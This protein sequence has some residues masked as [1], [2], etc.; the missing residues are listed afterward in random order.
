MLIP[1]L[2]RCCIALVT[3]VALTSEAKAQ[4]PACPVVAMHVSTPADEAFARGDYPEAE[5]LYTHALAESS[6]DELQDAALVRT[7]LRE[8]KVAEAARE[9]AHLLDTHPAS[10]ALLTALAEVQFRQGVPWVAANTLDRVTAIDPCFARAHL[11]RSRLDRAD[12]MYR[13]ERSEI[14]TAYEIDSS[15]GEITRSWRQTVSTANDAVGLD[16]ALTSSKLDAAV[17][18]HAEASLKSLLSGLHEDS[19]TCRVLPADQ[20]AVLKLLPSRRD[21]KHI[22][23]FKLVVKLSQTSMVLQ[24]DTAASGIYISRTLAELNG[25]RQAED[26]P[27]GTV[28]APSVT[29]GPLEFK[30]C[31]LGV[32]E[33][34]FSDNV[35]GFL[36][37]DIFS[38]FLIKLDHPNHELELSPLPPVPEALL[39]GNRLSTS[40]SDALRGFN[41][42]YHRRQFLLVPVTLNGKL[43]K[44]FV[45]DSGVRY[46]TISSEVA[47]AVSTTRLNFTNAETTSSGT[48]NVYRDSF[49]FNL[50]GLF[51]RN[52]SPILEMEVPAT[53]ANIGMKLGGLLG[54]DTLH[55]MTIWLDYRDGL[56]KLEDVDPANSAKVDLA[57]RVPSKKQGLQSRSAAATECPPD[58]TSTHPFKTLI[59]A[60]PTGLWD[61][62]SLKSGEI[63]YAKVTR[64]WLTPGCRL[65]GGA[66][67]YGHVATVTRSK[68]GG[69]AE[70][71]LIFDQGD[72]TG[73]PRRYL[74][75]NVVGLLASDHD[76]KALHDALPVEVAGGGRRLGDAAAAE[77]GGSDFDLNPE[78][79]PENVQAG[80]VMRMPGVELGLHAGPACSM[81]MRGDRRDLRIA[82]TT[83]LLFTM[84]PSQ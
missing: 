65:E 1:S 62:G 11:L 57:A 49:D 42:V 51:L 78:L 7:L 18:Q 39:P 47:H 17:R 48:V 63:L 60:R 20:A 77:N 81:L 30:D 40:D 15:D 58:D 75:L 14:Q 22:D 45:L 13:S 43:R 21:G 66:I 83:E 12:S 67:L 68:H 5:T 80:M 59:T 37:T 28:F 73:H 41:P 38:S 27:P 33:T 44:L 19:Q 25:L 10:A 76:R 64:T 84:D 26:G 9:A 4:V 23:G 31:T 54:F 8:K 46:T 70:L 69:P 71:A 6:N 79:I 3:L 50:A 29:I 55:S 61:S 34:S 52:R 72:C 2:T 53:E 82:P 32:S 36:G 74:N 56:V 35:A 16:K 24:I